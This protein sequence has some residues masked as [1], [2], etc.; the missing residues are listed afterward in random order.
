[1][2]RLL[3]L[4][5]ELLLFFNGFHSEWMDHVMILATKTIFSLP[6]YLILLYLII[7]NKKWDALFYLIGVAVTIAMA[8]QITS[9]FMKPFF[10]RLRP[11]QEPGLIDLLHTVNNYKGGLYGFASSHAANTFGVAMFLWL[12]FKGRYHWISVIFIWA[13]FISYTR[14]YLGVHYPGDILAG[15]IIGLICGWAGYLFA[16]WLIS[17]FSKQG[18]DGHSSA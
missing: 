14:I 18:V 15:M 16:N 10:A 12:L 17:K 8:D 7:R 3:E 1:M 9:T 5:Q 6:L 4:D 2:Q 11:S 13:A